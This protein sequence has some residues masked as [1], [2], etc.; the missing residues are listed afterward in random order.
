VT[1]QEPEAGQIDP[2]RYRPKP[3]RDILLSLGV[4]LAVAF[5]LIASLLISALLG[6]ALPKT[7]AL[8]DVANEAVATAVFAALFGV[9]F[10]YLPDARIPWRVA[11]A[12]GSVTAILFALGKWA[13]GVYLASGDVGG[14]YG[15]AGSLAVLLVWVY[16]SGAI[17]FFGA[18]VT[19]AWLDVRGETI[20]PTAHAK[21][22]ENTG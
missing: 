12:G 14:A 15:A 10:R 8:W 2:K 5:V 20:E 9:L 11:A 1:T 22:R 6:W 4:I 19:K 17:F 3:V 13:I 21:H 18:E 7:G 16:Y